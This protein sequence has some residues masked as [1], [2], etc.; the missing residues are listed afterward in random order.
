MHS[1]VLQ[2][3]SESKKILCGI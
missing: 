3:V 2:N 1:F